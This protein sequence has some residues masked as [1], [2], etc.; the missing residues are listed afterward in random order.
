MHIGTDRQ[1]F[2]NKAKKLIKDIDENNND[3]NWS[4][5]S[6]GDLWALFHKALKAKQ[7]YVVRITWIKGHATDEMVELALPMLRT[8]KET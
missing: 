2:V 4:L 3:I 6:D 5:Q 8:E 1:A 7:T